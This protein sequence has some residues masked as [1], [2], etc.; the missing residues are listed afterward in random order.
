VST[1]SITPGTITAFGNTTGYPAH[2]PQL[3][4]NHQI[5]DAYVSQGAKQDAMA[6][7]TQV[8]VKRLYGRISYYTLDASRSDPSKNLIFLLPV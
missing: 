1:Y 5:E 2:N 6:N 7:N 4:L 8:Q 3:P